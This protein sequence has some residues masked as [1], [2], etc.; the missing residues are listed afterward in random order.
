M[1]AELLE[2]ILACPRLPSL[3]AI[4]L[5]VV[6]LT[7]DENVSM[8]ELAGRIEC[9]QALAAKIVRTVNSSFYGLRQP[10]ASVRRALV[11]LGLGPVKT[12]ALGFSLVGGLKGLSDSGFDWLSYWR[13][14]LYSAAAA[15]C[16]A[17]TMGRTDVS[18][19]AFLAALMQDIGMVAMYEALGDKYSDVLAATGGEHRKLVR[20]EVEAFEVAHT[21][22]GAM[23]AHRWRLPDR[24][25]IPI[26]YHERPTA[27][28]G[29]CAEIARLVAL[30]VLVHDVLTEQDT[31]R[32]LRRLYERARSLCGADE[33]TCEAV[34]Q[35]ISAH[36]RELSRLF[37]VDTGTCPNAEELLARAERQLIELSKANGGASAALLDGGGDELFARLPRDPLTGVAG[38]EAFT[39][40]VTKAFAIAMEGDHAATVVHVAVEGLDRIAQSMGEVVRD[41]ALL[42]LATLL[43][44]EFEPLGGLICR[45]GQSVFSVVLPDVGR[46]EAMRAMDEFRKRVGPASKAW[47]PESGGEPLPVSVSV[48]L[49]TI[50]ATTRWAFRDQRSLVGASA[51]ATQ[52]ARSSGGNCVRAFVPKAAA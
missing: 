10:C 35:C 9:D 39:L 52:V 45:I 14:G 43:S 48:G 2:E 49:A 26:K 33:S 38:Q 28:P 36:A 11:M 8:D 46:H 50:D 25:V 31:A 3:P 5:E 29:E 13:R 7:S 16:F 23:L 4:A 37:E 42:G 20:H 40:A 22:I 24:L 44:R 19:E 1:N 32:A 27:A 47:S 51:R 30:G 12:L 15:R 34:I 17:E 6:E 41:E 18:D 21:D